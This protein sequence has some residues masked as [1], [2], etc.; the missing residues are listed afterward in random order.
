VRRDP[1]TA[2]ALL[3]TVEALASP[4]MRG[5]EPNTPEDVLARALITSRM[6]DAGL[7]TAGDGFQHPFT[8]RNDDDDTVETAN[9]VG[10][11]RGGDPAVAREV[12][13]VGA[14]HDHLG[15]N[16]RQMYPGA[17][18]DASGVA[19]VL[20]LA[21][22]LAARA[23]RPRRTVAFVAFGA[24]EAGL[25]GSRAYVR[26]PPPGLALRDTAF[27]LNLDMVGTWSS[28]RCLNALHTF[29]GTLGRTAL[30]ALLP[31]YTDLRVDLGEPG[32]DSDHLSFCDAGI[33]TAF[34][35]TEDRRC[36]HRPCD[37]AANLDAAHLAR[38]AQLARDLTLRVADAD[39]LAA[40]RAAGC[41]PRRA[42]RRP[43]GQPEVALPHPRAGHVVHEA[44]ARHAPAG[45][46]GGTV[47]EAHGHRDAPG[48]DRGERRALRVRDPVAAARHAAGA[49]VDLRV[50]LRAELHGAPGA[51]PV[52]GR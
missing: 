22:D 23:P 35:F 44:T 13:V 42:S 18:D 51:R 14:H 31:A 6:R 52:D 16:A 38:I 3:A 37:T 17:N 47:V 8:F 39:D 43:H 27:M 12:I 33:P 32:E 9:V 5:R 26:A 45:R 29:P 7:S 49:A 19:V 21:E 34:F 15:A 30:D 25:Q 24:E 50:R 28:A 41:G 10:V 2:A 1:L 48:P 40:A 11:L 46:G 36:Y 4:S 20:A